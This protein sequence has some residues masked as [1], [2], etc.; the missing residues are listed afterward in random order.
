MEYDVQSKVMKVLKENTEGDRTLLR[1]LEG[2]YESI[3]NLHLNLQ[4]PYWQSLAYWIDIDSGM[5][6][7]PLKS[8]EM[9][10]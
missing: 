5:L 8:V 4:H 3:M 2:E 1:D 9:C 7:L 10:V 6:T